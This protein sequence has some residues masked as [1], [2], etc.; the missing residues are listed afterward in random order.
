MFTV[1]QGDAQKISVSPKAD[2]GQW[3]SAVSQLF[4]SVWV[5]TVE[6]MRDTLRLLHFGQVRR[7]FSYSVTETFNVNF[8]LHFSQRNS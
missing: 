1:K 7:F 5:I 6:K 8:F 3:G 2:L 4:V